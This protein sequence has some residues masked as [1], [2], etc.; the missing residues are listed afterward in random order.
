MTTKRK[1]KKIAFLIVIIFLTLFLNQENIQGRE[2]PESNLPDLNNPVVIY[3]PDKF[4][5]CN[6]RLYFKYEHILYRYNISDREN[7]VYIYF[8]NKLFTVDIDYNRRKEEST[9]TINTYDISN[10][11]FTLIDSNEVAKQPRIYDFNILDDYLLM[12]KCDPYV[13][14]KPFNGSEIYLLPEEIVDYENN[15][16]TIETFLLESDFLYMITQE[17]YT[18]FANLLIID[19]SDISNP[20]L[21]GNC[22]FGDESMYLPSMKKVNDML[23]L[24]T[25]DSI[26]YAFNVS[27]TTAPTFEGDFS[28]SG[29]ESEIKV[30][31]NFAV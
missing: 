3:P 7:I 22:S 21:F 18:D 4:H 29:Y 20:V 17:K 5:L 6:D 26:L 13:N 12:Y 1:T 31:G 30:Y 9:L 16:I 25:K 11:K 27:N 15:Y 14:Y 10:D 28:I 23:Y 24:E 2:K 19:M 8:E